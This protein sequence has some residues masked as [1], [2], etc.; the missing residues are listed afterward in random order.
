MGKRRLRVAIYQLANGRI[1]FGMGTQ[2]FGWQT[3]SRRTAKL[4]SRALLGI[5][6][7]LRL[8]VPAFAQAEKIEAENFRQVVAL[9]QIACTPCELVSERHAASFDAI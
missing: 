7:P 3:Q 6:I 8:Q 1:A 4:I 5:L 2:R 9:N